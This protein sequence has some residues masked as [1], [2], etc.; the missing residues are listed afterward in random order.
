MK[1]KLILIIR[2]TV[3]FSWEIVHGLPYWR[4]KGIFTDEVEIMRDYFQMLGY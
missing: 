3:R 2:G 4:S 1:Y